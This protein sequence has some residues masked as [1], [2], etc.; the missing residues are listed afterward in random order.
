VASEQPFTEQASRQPSE[1]NGDSADEIVTRRP[2]RIEA[3]SR[4]FVLNFLWI[5][6]GAGALVLQFLRAFDG[7]YLS[8]SMNFAQLG[9]HLAAGHGFVTTFLRPVEVAL[10]PRVPA[11]EILHAPLY[12]LLLGMVF[13][14]LPESDEVVAGVSACFFIATFMLIYL[15]ASKVFDRGAGILAA[16]LFALNAL[17]LGYAVSGLHVTLWAFLL[18]LVVYL[19]YTNRGS[20]RRSLAAGAVLGLCWLTEYMT[21]ALIVPALAAA[22]YAHSESRRRHLGWF[23]AGLIA[24]MIPWWV[25]NLLVARDPFFTLERYLIAMFTGAHP[26]HSLFRAADP[27]ALNLWQ[28]LA[29]EPRQVLMKAILGLA[30]GYRTIPPLVGLYVVGF[31]VV[32]M[33]RPLAA[34]RQNLVRKVA[35]LLLVFLGVV[36]AVHNPSAELFFVLVPLIVALCAG[37]FM[38]L[39]REWIPALR[40]RAGAVA[41]FVA[42]SAYPALVSWALPQPKAISS[43]RNLEH[44]QQALPEKAVVVTDAPWAVAW[45][46]KRAAVWLP[47]EPKDFEAVDR[48]IGIDAIYLST[49]LPTYPAAE[50]ALMWQRIYAARAAP[51]G[52]EAAALPEPG[53]VL[54][55]KA[56][57]P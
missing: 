19:L 39:A 11:P 32:A 23:A 8:E 46:A 36:G 25:R 37:Y 48:K 35:L 34:P 33:M 30:S 38:I 53:E 4:R 24:I 7:L 18:T 40:W 47:L 54:L 13:E 50:P 27:S 10:Y 52:F 41:V 43:R 14:I 29:A 26:G 16:V 57:A 9:R 55:I 17:A 42:I 56:A 3:W 12:P 2:D 49:L 1:S 20:S 51:P 15:L 21:L 22:Y 44:L 31:F 28:L 5:A 6:V 45:Y